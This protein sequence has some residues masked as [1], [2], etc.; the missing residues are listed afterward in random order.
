MSITSRYK[1]RPDCLT[2]IQRKKRM[3]EA[4]EHLIESLQLVQNI[5]FGSK[6]VK[7]DDE[8]RKQLEITAELLTKN[9]QARR[10]K[11]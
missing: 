11:V 1:E 6:M 3:E 9:I 4:Q 2:H 5:I 8:Q 7:N 10:I